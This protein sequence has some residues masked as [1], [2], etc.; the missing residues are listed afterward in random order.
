MSFRSK[1]KKSINIE[2]KKYYLEYDK[3]YSQIEKI[4]ESTD[5]MKEASEQT[6]VSALVT[7]MELYLELFMTDLHHE[8]LKID[9]FYR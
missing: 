6:V 8:L 2:W 7:K 3:L 4:Q 1:F 9:T 5:S